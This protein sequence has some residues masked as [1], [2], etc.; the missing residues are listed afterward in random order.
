MGVLNK[1]VARLPRPLQ[2]SARRSG[3]F[4][5]D[6][7]Y[8]RQ[9]TVKMLVS[10]FTLEIPRHHHL[11]GMQK[12]QPYRNLCVGITAKFVTE[13]YIDATIVDIGANIG[14]TAAVIAQYCGN[15][16]IVV[17]A[18]DYYA[19]ILSRNVK[20]FP[21]PIEIERVFVSDG[22]EVR[23]SLHY[24]GGT[25]FF[26]ESS[27]TSTESPKT[28]KR[29]CDIADK[30]ALLDANSLFESLRGIGYEYFIYW[31]DPGFHVLSTRSMAAIKDLNHYL[32]K[33]M[34]TGFSRGISNYDVLC[35]HESD[36]DIFD[37]VSSYYAAM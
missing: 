3:R 10:G 19:E 30:E 26:E 24:R 34:E 36:K 18:S 22:N 21:N 33:L 15:K 2:D 16:M 13:K 17:E 1:V 25:A 37:A 32:F 11:V 28:T 6:K 8:A 31:D 14:D 4:L 7:M 20:Q 23:G 35:L 9:S 5:R 12:S 29:L 27:G